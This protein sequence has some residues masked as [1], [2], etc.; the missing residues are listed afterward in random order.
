M[1]NAL[2]SDQLKR[3]AAQKHPNKLAQHGIS[4]LIQRQVVW[5]LRNAT[6]DLF[7][8]LLVPFGADVNIISIVGTEQKSDQGYSMGFSQPSIYVCIS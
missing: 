1:V 4:L 7:A 8:W 5:M 6:E 2:L 3:V